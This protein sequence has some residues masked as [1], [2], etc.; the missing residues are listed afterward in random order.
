VRKLACFFAVAML[1]CLAQAALP[2]ASAAE[3]KPVLTVSFAGYDE[4]KSSLEAVGKLIGKPGS[5]QGLEAMLNAMTGGKVL[6]GLKKDAPWGLMFAGV[7]APEP[8]VVGFLPL[9][10]VKPLVEIL[11]A[12][13]GLP[14]EENNGVFEIP[15]PRG[16]KILVMQR[17]AWTCLS[18]VKAQLETL[19]EDPGKLLGDLSKNYLL[20]LRISMKELPEKMIDQVFAGYE[21]LLHFGMPKNPNESDEMYAL[22]MQ[23][24][25]S[26]LSQMK[27]TVK[28]LDQLLIGVRVDSSTNRIYADLDVTPKSGS[29][30]AAQVA[31][32][33]TAKTDFAGFDLPGA[34]LTGHKSV[35]LTEADAAQQKASLEKVQSLIEEEL[36]NQELSEKDA[37]LAQELLKDAFGAIIQTIEAKKIDNGAVV[38]ADE[39][40]LF[41]AVGLSVADGKKLEG[42]LEKLVAAAKE[43]GIEEA[44]Q[45]KLNAEQHQGIRFHTFSVPTPGEKL[46]PFVGDTLEVIFGVGDKQVYVAAGRDAA[47]TL[48]EII[49]QSKAQAGKK[50]SPLEV[51]LAVAPLV[52]MLAAAAPENEKAPFQM[53]ATMM[54][55]SSGKDHINLTMQTTEGGFRLRLDVEEDV[56]KALGAMIPMGPGMPMPPAPGGTPFG[57]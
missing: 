16:P 36:K 51:K 42:V 41:A 32:M 10:D 57:N 22:R 26:S 17:G 8:T 29:E 2:P 45:I 35:E 49:D 19:P 7:D 11:K 47:K 44:K 33:K 5:S 43:E 15:T 25:Q 9:A 52:K 53:I 55:Q 21:M 28:E 14:V 6:P 54:Q 48:K 23:T 12:Q 37:K 18:N 1:V 34:M 20:A 3:L 4:M 30:L 40:T 38:K 27:K 13:T 56:L 39:K 46:K 31:L 24:V 50:V